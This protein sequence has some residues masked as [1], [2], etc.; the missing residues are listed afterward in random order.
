MIKTPTTTPS[1]LT[2]AW[3]SAPA[4]E[5]EEQN[6]KQLFPDFFRGFQDLEA[7][8]GEGPVDDDRRPVDDEY[9]R[10]VASEGASDASDVTAQ[11]TTA[12][13]ASLLHGE[14]LA[15][16]VALHARCVA[17]LAGRPRPCVCAIASKSSPASCLAWHA[18]PQPAVSGEGRPCQ[19]GTLSRTHMDALAKL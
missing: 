17:L 16:L 9:E 13:A 6:Y 5:E 15:D 4:Q 7:L 3:S 11:A 14:V 12:A 1:A 10:D 18:C 19:Q 2:C 8:E